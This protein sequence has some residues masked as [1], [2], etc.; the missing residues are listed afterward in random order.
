[1]KTFEIYF[2][3]LTEKAQKELLATFETTEKDENWEV[4]S[5]ATIARVEDE[6]ENE[7]C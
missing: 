7:L 4:F 6:E 5:L 2:S 1:M 3:D